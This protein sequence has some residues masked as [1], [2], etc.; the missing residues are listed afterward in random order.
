MSVACCDDRLAGGLA[1]RYAENDGERGSL[2]RRLRVLTEKPRNARLGCF[3]AGD[4]EHQIGVGV[5]AGRQVEAVEGKKDVSG[6]RSDSFVAVDKRVILDEMEQ[7]GR[8]HFAQAGVSVL[9]P[10][11][12]GRHR[13]GRLK[14]RPISYAFAAAVARKLVAMNGY[15]FVERQKRRFHRIIPPT[16]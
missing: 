1:R 3:A 6:D 13:G 10:K 5:L 12:D 7:I 8:R 15:D 14:Q 16:V 11:P 9:S 2:P 4:G